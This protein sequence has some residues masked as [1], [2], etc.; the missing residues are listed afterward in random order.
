EFNCQAAGRPAAQPGARDSLYWPAAANREPRVPHASLIQRI[1]SIPTRELYFFALYRVLEAGLVAALVFSPLSE[2]VG[3][4]R[5][6]ALGGTVA[7][8]YLLASLALL[9]VSRNERWLVPLVFSGT[10][11]DIL[12]ATLAT[13]ALPSVGAGIAMMLLFNVAGG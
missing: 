10:C 6:A 4:P 1:E 3:S 13:H 12:A 11:L 5:S 9:A 8:V 7:V 2:M